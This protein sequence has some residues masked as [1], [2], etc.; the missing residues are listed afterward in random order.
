MELL[1]LEDMVGIPSPALSHV[2]PFDKIIERDD[3]DA[4]R[5]AARELAY[6]HF[7]THWES[8]YMSD[9]EDKRAQRVIKD[10]FGEDSDWTPDDLVVEGLRKYE[11]LTESEHV[12]LLKAARTAAHHLTTHFETLKIDEPKDAKDVIANL[13]KVGDVVEGIDKLKERIEKHESKKNANRAGAET[14]KYSEG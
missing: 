3:S 12:K 10:I 7:M 5:Q 11:D 4:H 2:K 9:P 13:S 1:E 6:I 14:N 8:P